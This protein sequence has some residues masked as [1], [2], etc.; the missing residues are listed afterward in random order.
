MK[1]VVL[2]LVPVFTCALNHYYFYK[3]N[4]Q[5]LLICFIIYIYIYIYICNTCK[6]HA[7]LIHNIYT[8]RYI[9]IYIIYIYIY[10]LSIYVIIYMICKNIHFLYLIISGVNALCWWPFVYLLDT[11]FQNWPYDHVYLWKKSPN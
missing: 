4:L 7:I 6:I 8:N 1:L 9:F 3:G 10:P 5:V 2:F 11:P